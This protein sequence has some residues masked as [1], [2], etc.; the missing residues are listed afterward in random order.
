MAVMVSNSKRLTQN[1]FY[2]YCRMALLMVISLY[3]S[4]VVLNVLGV[5]DYGIYNLVGS[6]ILMF[7]SLRTVFASSTQRFL[8]FEMGQNRTDNLVKIFNLSLYINTVI[9]VIF[10]ILV[11]I[12]GCWFFEYKINIPPERLYAAKV[13]FQFSLISSLISIFTSTLDSCVVAHERMDF[14]AIMSL[15]EGFMKLLIAFL[16][17]ALEYDKL[18]LYGFLMFCISLIVFISNILFCKINFK[19]CR[20]LLVWDRDYIKKMSE[21][22]G[23]NFFGNTAYALSQN[24]LNMVMNVFGGPL[25]NAARGI[26]FQV[27]IVLFQLIANISTVVKPYIIK[28]YSAGEYKKTIDLI[29]MSSKIY[30]I[31][32]FCVVTIFTFLC[33][34]II[35]IWLGQI[36]EYVVDF[37]TLIMIYSL[38]RTLHNPIDVLFFAVGNLKLYQLCEGVVL[39]LPVLATYITLRMGIGYNSAFINMIVFELVNF[40]I[41]LYIASK[42]CMLDRNAYMRKVMKPCAM[43][44]IMYYLTFSILSPQSDC[45]ANSLTK[46]LILIAI[47]LPAFFYG[48]FNNDE[49]FQIV[50]LMV[51]F[52]YKRRMNK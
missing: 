20:L 32:Q 19:E 27:N 7:T 47:S 6:I 36:P 13:V 12:V 39:S 5:S 14:Y 50:K 10:L 26:A 11:E 45:L 21:F 31:I 48:G 1:T 17:S 41:V 37:V 28:Q 15:V 30:F 4:R 34:H 3:T 40:L 9:A 35:H 24:G 44:F 29:F 51:S 52:I 16:I 25:V 8:S 49:R 18:I 23:W 43:L 22:A 2:M 46:S 38:V 33:P 42:K